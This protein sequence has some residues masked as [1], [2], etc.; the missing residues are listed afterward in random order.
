MQ[1]PH[2]EHLVHTVIARPQLIPRP[3]H[4]VAD[5]SR[6]KSAYR[7]VMSECARLLTCASQVAATMRP[8]RIDCSLMVA[9]P[10]DGSDE[11]PKFIVKA[12]DCSGDSYVPVKPFS[13]SQPWESASHDQE[14]E[15]VTAQRVVASHLSGAERIVQVN[16]VTEKVGPYAKVTGLRPR[17]LCLM[18]IEKSILEEGSM[19]EDLSQLFYYLVE[20][21]ALT[22]DLIRLV[23]R[24]CPG[25]RIVCL[26]LIENDEEG[27]KCLRLLAEDA[28][29]V[30]LKGLVDGQTFV[31]LDEMKESVDVILVIDLD[32]AV[33][34][35]KRRDWSIE[36][37]FH[38]SPIHG[39]A[40]LTAVSQMSDVIIID[41]SANSHRTKSIYPDSWIPDQLSSGLEQLLD[42]LDNSRQIKV[43]FDDVDQARIRHSTFVI[44]LTSS[45]EDLAQVYKHRH[46][47]L[48]LF[49]APPILTIY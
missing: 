2:D 3:F 14:P 22:L 4:E 43:Y 34:V 32:G 15:L 35:W 17:C 36:A 42:D 6:V 30:C 20:D 24:Y 40:S 33:N 19:A 25:V 45:I 48:S 13:L 5:I 37:M 46:I 26:S 9:E 27:W 49:T 16:E 28:E 21:S 29:D 7:L 8:Q 39:L 12:S 1:L 11:H 23:E 10:I 41:K 31:D 18:Q 47:A 38:F 44:G